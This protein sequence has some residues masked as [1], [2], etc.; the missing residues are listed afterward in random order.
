M[1]LIKWL[2]LWTVL[3][4]HSAT[5]WNAPP[6][7]STGQQRTMRDEIKREVREEQRQDDQTGYFRPERPREMRPPRR[8]QPHPRTALPSVRR[9]PPPL[10]DD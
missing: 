8:D 2:T 7:T 1:A 4:A 10:G 5:A 9:N 3:S 6:P